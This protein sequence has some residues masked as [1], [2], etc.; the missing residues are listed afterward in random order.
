MKL[1]KMCEAALRLTHLCDQLNLVPSEQ[2]GFRRGRAAEDNLARLVQTVQ[3]GWNRPKARGKPVD[4]KTADKFILTAYDFAR[5]YDTIDH[6]MLYVKL[7]RRLPRCL[8]TWIYRFLR[9]RRASVE[10]NGTRNAERPF[11]AGLP[12][13]SVL[14]ST[15]YTL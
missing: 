8:S 12:Q 6:K 7:L 5:A 2:V 1:L 10:I 11:R 14:A 4:G 13:G 3:D 15:L 9:D